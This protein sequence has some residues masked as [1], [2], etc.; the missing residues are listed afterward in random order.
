MPPE[1]TKISRFEELDVLS[2][3]NED[4]YELRGDRGR[5]IQTALFN[6]K[7]LTFFGQDIFKDMNFFWSGH[8]GSSAGINFFVYSNSL[9]ILLVC[10]S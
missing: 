4:S 5:T 3:G 1:K 9:S 8:F 7:I 2:T 10:A 6:Q